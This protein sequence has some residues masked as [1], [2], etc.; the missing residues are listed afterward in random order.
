MKTSFNLYTK[1]KKMNVAIIGAGN[2]GKAIINGLSSQPQY[3][4]TTTRKSN[5]PIE[6]IDPKR[7]AIHTDNSKA[8]QDAQ[9]IIIAVKPYI[10]KEVLSEI[11]D[12]LNENQIIVSLA[13]GYNISDIQKHISTD[14]AI[15]RVMPNTAASVNE[16]MTLISCSE[17][18]KENEKKIIKD[19]FIPL[20]E[21]E[22]IA[23]ALMDSAT[24]LAAC[25]TAYVLRFI[26]SMTQGGIQIGFSSKLA[27]KIVNQTV[28]GAAVLVQNSNTHPE[29]EIDKVT[30]PK[31]CT[32]AGL[33]EM[34]HQGFS[35]AL[36]KGI[37]SSYKELE[38]K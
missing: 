34:E 10:I 11:K 31:G 14:V 35:S 22:I 38:K 3:I 19:I 29:E 28:K 30:T 6:G 36:I 2:L 18:T 4:I 21:V 25:G 26:R 1:I 9:V 8:I 13:A 15:F 16:S 12:S 20:G 23:E 7:V 27:A 17:N 24:V 32:I 37:I 5:K 33:N